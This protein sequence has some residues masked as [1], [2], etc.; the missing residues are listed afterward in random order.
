MGR[1]G[2]SHQS[3][4]TLR[5]LAVSAETRFR[6]ARLRVSIT[7][8]GSL[9][10]VIILLTRVDVGGYKYLVLSGVLDRESSVNRD[11]GKKSEKNE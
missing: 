3:I 2:D 8:V 6:G 11:K 4:E 5:L 10:V 1:F 7:I 9:I